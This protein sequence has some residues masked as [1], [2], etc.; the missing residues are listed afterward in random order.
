MGTGDGGWE[1]STARDAP[2]ALQRLHGES[3]NG[4]RSPLPFFLVPVLIA[5][6]APQPLPLMVGREATRVSAVH[7][8]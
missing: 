3:M 6:P 5:P 2:H 1:T 7:G 8:R 4:M